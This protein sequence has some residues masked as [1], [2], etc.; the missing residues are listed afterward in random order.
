MSELM[1]QEQMV[2]AL[3]GIADEASQS[4]NRMAQ[5]AKMLLNI[6]VKQT[7]LENKIEEVSVVGE[8]AINRLNNLDCSNIEGTPRQ[9]LVAIVRKYAM[10]KGILYNVAWGDFRR[11]FDLAYRTNIEARLSNYRRKYGAK[12]LTMPEYLERVG[13][14]EDALRVADKMINRGR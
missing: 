2:E 12:G 10:D 11:R 1:V 5:I 3:Q 13:L 8:K 9:R 6:T 4:S 14:I 7:E